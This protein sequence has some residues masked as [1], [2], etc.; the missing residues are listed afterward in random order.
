L[1]STG[2]VKDL[3]DLIKCPSSNC[4]EDKAFVFLRTTAQKIIN[5]TSVN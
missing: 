1:E 3:Q 5:V 4:G 2:N